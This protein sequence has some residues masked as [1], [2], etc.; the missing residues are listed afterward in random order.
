MMK[1]SNDLRSPSP[2]SWKCSISVPIEDQV[3]IDEKF[4]ISE[5]KSW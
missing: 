1:T 2:F 5:Y 4:M 3:F